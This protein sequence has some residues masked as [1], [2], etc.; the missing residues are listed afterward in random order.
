MPTPNEL[1][2]DAL[3]NEGRPEP[4]TIKVRGKQFVTKDPLMIGFAEYQAVD[5]AD[6]DQILDALFS[7]DDLADF[8]AL[9]LSQHAMNILGDRLA[10]HYFGGDSPGESPA[11]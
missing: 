9:N 10:D 11:S 4:M 7:P 1:D 8:K 3:E 2:L 5:W 6:L